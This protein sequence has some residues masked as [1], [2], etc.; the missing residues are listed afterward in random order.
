MD[1]AAAST[2]LAYP[3]S[4][5]FGRVDLAES[6]WTRRLPL[7]LHNLGAGES[8]LSLA[9]EGSLG[10][11][12]AVWV[13][14][15]ALSLAPGQ[16]QAVWVE[17]EV[18]TSEMVYP[19]VEPYAFYGRILITDG[20]TERGVPFAL[21]AP[22]SSCALQTQVPYAECQA[23][24]EF[25]H[26]TNGIW[27]N[28]NR[29]W[30]ET[31][32]CSWAGVFCEDGHVSHLE[33]GR[34]NLSGW[35]PTSLDQLTHLRSLSIFDNELYCTLPYQLGRLSRLENLNAWSNRFSGPIPDE[36]GNLTS[37]EI[38][39][40]DHNALGGDV[41]ATITNLTNLGELNLGRNMFY[42][43]D[44]ATAAFLDA[45]SPGW[46]L[47]QTVPPQGLRAEVLSETSVRL[48]WEPVAFNSGPGYYIITY[49]FEPGGPAYATHTTYDKTTSEYVLSGLWPGR[50]H[51]ISVSTYSAASDFQKNELISPASPEIVVVPGVRTVTI[52][53]LP[54]D[55]EN[56]IQCTV[57]NRVLSVAVLSTPG[58]DALT[59]D[60]TTVT[61]EGAT[62]T[63]RHKGQ[64]GR[65]VEDVNRDGLPDLIF[66]FRLGETRLMCSSTEGVLSG[67][68]FS[69][70]AIEGRDRVQ[71]FKSP[72]KP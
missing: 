7:T 65:R 11:G 59:V 45:K 29:N 33:L 72:G 47:T 54:D 63:H 46:R 27:W 20:V 44:P 4:L 53:I 22:P 3:G 41:P 58:F 1:R 50:R 61:F 24:E 14:P 23:L 37:L 69:G 36:Y 38:L 21:T 26:T 64:A 8:E 51:Y 66:H 31:P 62:D 16:S 49:G 71:M 18:N 28:N 39:L 25:Y 43:D 12:V 48:S 34:N 13:E 5:S 32:P 6:R 70:Q 56:K 68:T 42:A 30:L 15:A 2:F 9:V 35:L 40:L 67:Y 52:D 55:P 57:P 60:H 19:A 17:V 10:P